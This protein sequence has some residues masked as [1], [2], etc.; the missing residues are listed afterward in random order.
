MGERD[1]FSGMRQRNERCPEVMG[2]SFPWRSV[3][4][5]HQ[6]ISPV[7]DYIINLGVKR[8]GD[9]GSVC[10]FNIFQ[11]HRSFVLLLYSPVIY[12]KPVRNNIEVLFL[13]G[14]GSKGQLLARSRMW[15]YKSLPSCVFYRD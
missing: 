10:H 5:L 3:E 7:V 1:F 13:S 12:G 14:S 2:M 9:P 6:H 15:L 4:R 11:M 8:L